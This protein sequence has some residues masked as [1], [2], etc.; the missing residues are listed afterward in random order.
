MVVSEVVGG[1]GACRPAE[2]GGHLRAQK[3]DGAEGELVGRGDR[4]HLEGDVGRL[5]DDRVGGE[6]GDDLVD[7]A[8]VGVGEPDQLGERQV[9]RVRTDQL[10]GDGAEPALGQREGLVATVGVYDERGAGGEDAGRR[11]LG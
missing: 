6:R 7:G 11:P 1:A 3:L 2:P 4:V 8:D 5:R 10:R 9:G